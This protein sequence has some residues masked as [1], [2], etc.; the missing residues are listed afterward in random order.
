MN[1]LKIR[2]FIREAMLVGSVATAAAVFWSFLVAEAVRH[3]FDFNE[4]K[5][6][7]YVGLPLFI[8]IE[9]VMITY[10]PER[11]RKLGWIE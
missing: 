4:E 8:F 5:T 6:L 9:Y 2:R 10:M 3:L 1:W 11:L 7:L